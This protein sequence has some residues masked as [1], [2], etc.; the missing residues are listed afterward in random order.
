ER[1][2]SLTAQ[3]R[4]ISQTSRTIPIVQP[5]PPKPELKDEGIQ[6]DEWAPA[7]IFV[8][9]PPSPARSFHRVGTISN[10]PPFQFVGTP[11][12]A[13][14]TSF[15]SSVGTITPTQATLAAP[16]ATR[17]LLRDSGATFGSVAIPR[18]TTPSMVGRQDRRQSVESA[19]SQGAP[20]AAEESVPAT[21]SQILAVPTPPV[22]KT[23]PPV[24][25]MPPPPPMPPPS[26]IPVRQKTASG[27][28]PRPTSPPPPELIQRATTPTFRSTTPSLHVPGSGR[29]I[30]RPHGASLPPNA[31]GLDLRQPV[32]TSSF[33]S[34]PNGHHNGLRS[35]I[36][37]VFDPPRREMSTTSL[38]S[39]IS[40]AIHSRRASVSSSRSSEVHHSMHQAQT[41]TPA[42]PNAAAPAAPVTPA[43]NQTG[44]P[45]DPNVIHAI[46]QTMIGEFMYKYTRRVV[47]KGH[48]EKRHRRF[49]WIHP[50]TKTLYW[51]SGDPGSAGANESTAKSAY[52]E[53][54]KSVLDPN[55]L[56]PGVYQYSIVV[57]TPQ[58]EMKFTAPNKERHDIWHTA[59]KYLLDRPSTIQP[60][61]ANGGQPMRPGPSPHQRKF[62]SEGGNMMTSPRSV[63]SIHSTHSYSITPRAMRSQTQL[64]VQSSH[65]KRPGTPAAEY[66]R[67]HEEDQKS[68]TR[69]VRS[70]R[71]SGPYVD[72]DDE[73]EAGEPAGE[74][75]FELNDE[76]FEAMEN[77][78]ACCDGEHDLGTLSR[79]PG[80]RQHHHHHHHHHNGPLNNISR[81][82]TPAERPTSPS[83]WSLRS[84]A[85][86]QSEGGSR[87]R[88]IRFINR[89]KSPAPRPS[90][91]IPR[92]NN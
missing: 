11:T 33:R 32:S 15:T 8:P 88:S 25:M 80:S 74:L 72:D 31:Q 27:P 30:P 13:A 89:G 19:F 71:Q 81:P 79:R 77:V 61:E 28:P 41:R 85:S 76:G 70:Y 87:F 50:Y 12:R 39:G 82:Q 23:K 42:R 90:L 49:F 57:A 55:P 36:A 52:I 40:S 75:S 9:V 47:G 73:Y 64:S 58:R 6:T 4:R 51:S 10:A 56:P 21:R 24:M 67:W 43:S 3:G 18:S 14:D 17:S 86:G 63:R 66:L 7:P 91:N 26:S 60:D 59:L 69:S 53:S 34:A 48:G 29:G 1:Y 44:D 62:S 65:G 35:P 2:A 78:R 5:A 20:N 83:G 38:L 54:V 45:T 37:G 46:T 92:T 68:P 22:D 84:K 16:A